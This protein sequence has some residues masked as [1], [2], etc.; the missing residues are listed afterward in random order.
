MVISATTKPRDVDEIVK[1]FGQLP[2]HR[3]IV[4]KLDETSVYGVILHTCVR[5]GVPLAFV[6]TGQGVPEDIDVAS[7]EKIARLILG[8]T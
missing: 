6:T 1:I 7:S 8:D 5:A 3:V 4:T 2:I